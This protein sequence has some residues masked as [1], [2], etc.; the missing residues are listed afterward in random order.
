MFNEAR[1]AK[2]RPIE[3]AH[4]ANDPFR[5]FFDG[6]D[7][8]ATEDATRFGD[9]EIPRKSL[10][11]EAS[12]KLDRIDQLRAEMDIV[13]AETDE[14]R[15]RM[16]CLALEKE[17]AQAQLTL[18]EIQLRAEKERAEVQT[19]KIE[20]LQSRLGSAVSDRESLAKEL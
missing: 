4:K 1:G 2:E 11:S 6:V 8:A 7:L 16:D 15:G 3:E 5:G 13:K 18:A 19:K 17:A 10:P 20:E 14:W 12:Q 9:L